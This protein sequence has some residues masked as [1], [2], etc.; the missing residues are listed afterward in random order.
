M[1]EGPLWG[2]SSDNACRARVITP[3]LIIIGKLKKI[4]FWHPSK[5]KNPKL[6]FLKKVQ[7]YKSI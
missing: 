2:L 7:I 3:V 5:I 1:P 6:V 4:P